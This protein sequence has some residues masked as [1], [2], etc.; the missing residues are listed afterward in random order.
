MFIVKSNSI[1]SRSFHRNTLRCRNVFVPSKISEQIY[2]KY[3]TKYYKYTLLISSDI[4]TSSIAYFFLLSSYDFS[5]VQL[6]FSL[7]ELKFGFDLLL[8]LNAILL[9]FEKRIGQIFNNF[10]FNNSISTEL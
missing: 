4:F 9:L 3:I 2:A 6:I 1:I 5:Y 10:P 8:N 7:Y